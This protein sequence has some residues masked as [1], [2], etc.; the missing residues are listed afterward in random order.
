MG[1]FN[2]TTM[3][4]NIVMTDRT[5]FR[6]VLRVDIDNSTTFPYSFVFDKTL[7]LSERPLMHPFVVSYTVPDVTY[8]FH[9]NSASL[10][11]FIHNLSRDIVINPNHEPSPSA[12]QLFKFSF[13]RFSAF[14]LEL[15]N[16]LVSSYSQLLDSFPEES[17]VGCNSES[18]YSN[19]NS[20][21]YVMEARV[22][23][24][25]VFRECEEKET[26]AFFINF[27]QAFFNVPSK[28]FFVT[29]RDG[30][31]NFN[32]AFDSSQAQDIVFDGCGTRKIISHAYSLYD[33][34]AFGSFNHTTGLFNTRNSKLSLQAYTF[35]L[36]VN[37]WLEFDIVPYLFIPSSIN[38]QLQTF[39]INAKGF[40][41]LWQCFDFDFS[42]GSCFHSNIDA[43]YIFKTNGGEGQFISILKN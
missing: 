28:V 5:L 22:F 18:V 16:Q 10:S 3:P 42:G 14:G 39:F 8:I 26:L 35:E 15:A 9:N 6:S 21:N 1:T 23:R 33:G 34:F 41:N 4:H 37:K 12:R 19:I 7:E 27:E 25:D 32:S 36:F 20:K 17:V 38:T 40:N 29:I 13:G 31:W 11:H 24:I 30:E 2:K 43:Q